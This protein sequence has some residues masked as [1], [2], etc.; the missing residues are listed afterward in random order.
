MAIPK[1]AYASQPGT[2]FLFGTVTFGSSGAVSSQDSQNF[3]VTKPS[4]TGIYRITLDSG[5]HNFV[6][7]NFTPMN[8][9]TAA[10]VS[11]QQKTNVSSGVVDF[12]CVSS[13]SAADATS[14][15]KVF[16][17]VAVKKYS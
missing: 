12:H 3:T 2:V 11:Y 16:I 7:V 17:T 15:H 10:D 8:G 6:G 1:A 5:Y 14:G 13:G 9:G 4:G